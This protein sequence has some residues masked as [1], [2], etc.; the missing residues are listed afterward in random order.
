MDE[1]EPNLRLNLVVYLRFLGSQAVLKIHNRFT[2]LQTTASNRQ[3]T[4]AIVS[5][6]CKQ[7][8]VTV[9]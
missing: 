5:R 7:R 9:S 8:P 4:P 1:C 3:L 6:S 2:Q